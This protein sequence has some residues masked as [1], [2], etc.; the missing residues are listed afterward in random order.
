MTYVI[1]TSQTD[2]DPYRGPL[3]C[4][5]ADRQPT[6]RPLAGKHDGSS[7]DKCGIGDNL[8]TTGNK[9]TLLDEQTDWQTDRCKNG[10]Q[11]YYIARRY[12]DTCSNNKKWASSINLLLLLIRHTSSLDCRFC[13]SATSPSYRLSFSN[14]ECSTLFRPTLLHSPLR[15]T[16]ASSI[17]YIRRRP[18]SRCSLLFRH[19]AVS[20]SAPPV[21]PSTHPAV[22]CRPCVCV[23]L[24]SSRRRAQYIVWN[25]HDA[26]RTDLTS[27]QL[28]ELRRQTVAA[29]ACSAP[30]TG[31]RDDVTCVAI[32]SRRLQLATP[33]YTQRPTDIINSMLRWR[34]NARII[35]FGYYFWRNR[36]NGSVLL[37]TELKSDNATLYMHC[38]IVRCGPVKSV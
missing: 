38:M 34:F 25:F 33:E 29:A 30:A 2:S 36:L 18:I 7:T 13:V 1:T 3:Y 9:S 24:P 12:G 35:R 31:T 10:G 6:W 14:T 21:H 16:A 27:W 8:T 15:P 11:C 26:I 37:I 22:Q 19:P 5:Q 4:R 28:I 32:L 20:H 23:V 17:C